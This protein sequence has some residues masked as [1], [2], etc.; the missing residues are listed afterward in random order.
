M[1]GAKDDTNKK[2]HVY[3][4]EACAASGTCDEDTT[5]LQLK[6]LKNV[7][8]HE[9]AAKTGETTE[10]SVATKTGVAAQKDKDQLLATARGSLIETQPQ[11]G[12]GVRS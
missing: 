12:H 2:R 9:A 3:V 5:L 7:L 11:R 1:V 8:R 10:T 4:S 6:H